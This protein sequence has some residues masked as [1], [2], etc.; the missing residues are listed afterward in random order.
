MQ[1]T[2]EGKTE[3]VPALDEEIDIKPIEFYGGKF[4]DRLGFLSQ[5]DFAMFTIQ[6]EFESVIEFTP[7]QAREIAAA[8][9]EWADN[10]GAD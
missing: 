5:L 1:R 2:F 7:Q 3:S 9:I 4:G 6:G 10:P 8:L